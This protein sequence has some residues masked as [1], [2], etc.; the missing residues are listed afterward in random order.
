MGNA[1]SNPGA[2][3]APGKKPEKVR[4]AKTHGHTRPPRM[5]PL[6]TLPPTSPAPQDAAKKKFEPKPLTRVG[7]KKNKAKAGGLGNS[8]LPKVVPST[9]CKLRAMKLERV[10]D[11]LLMEREFITNQEVLRPKEESD[12]LERDKVDEI[13]GL[14]LQVGSLEE[15][16]CGMR[17]RARRP[18]TVRTPP[19]HA[20]LSPTLPRSDDNHAII[21]TPNGPEYYV[22]ILSM[23]D[24]DLLEPNASVLLHN[25]TQAI[26]GV[27]GDDADP[28]V[29]APTGGEMRR[30]HPR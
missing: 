23:V 26:V 16:M 30:A 4:R 20:P 22:A 5:R 1:G 19:D 28:L 7:R 25:K 11:F 18:P 12:K 6:P 10:K 13:R 3:G 21:S 17:A 14:P 8:N 29:R 27:L 15:M 24:S 2:G 9:R